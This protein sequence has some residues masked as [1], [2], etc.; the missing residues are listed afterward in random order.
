MRHTRAGESGKAVGI[1]PNDASA[2]ATALAIKAP[3]GMIV[4]SPAPFAP[5][6][7]LGEG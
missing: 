4:P 3:V 2:L 6:G 1:A 7:L 5:S